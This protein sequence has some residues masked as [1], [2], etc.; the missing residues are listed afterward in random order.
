MCVSCLHLKDCSRDEVF[1]PTDENTTC[2]SIPL[3]QNN[4]LATK[5]GNDEQIW[6]P[7][8]YDKYLARLNTEEF[9]SICFVKF[10]SDFRSVNNQE[11]ARN[12]FLLNGTLG[13]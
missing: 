12:V 1:I 7:S 4:P 9:E 3:S 13:K 10:V 8:V 5:E 2:M 6:M 11:K